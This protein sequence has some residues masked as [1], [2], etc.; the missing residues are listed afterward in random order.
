MAMG[1]YHVTTTYAWQLWVLNCGHFVTRPECRRALVEL[2]EELS[3][4]TQLD[5]ANSTTNSQLT[6]L[7]QDVCTPGLQSCP[8]AVKICT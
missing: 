4:A 5:K 8:A 6:P 2:A 1:H 3:V 7:Y